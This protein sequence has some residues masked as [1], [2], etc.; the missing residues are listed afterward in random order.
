MKRVYV[1][2]ICNTSYN[3]ADALAKC[4]VQCEN[5]EKEAEAMAQADEAARLASEAE[6]KQS[7]EKLKAAIKSYNEKYPNHRFN[8]TFSQTSTSTT[9]NMKSIRKSE[10]R[11]LHDLMKILFEEDD[12]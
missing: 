1:C 7:Y 5:K 9:N 10:P 6:I 11:S 2:P 4:V 12:V 8:I 3:T